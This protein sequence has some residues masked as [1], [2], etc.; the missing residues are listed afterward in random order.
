MMLPLAIAATLLAQASKPQAIT[1]E[2][3]KFF[4]STIRPILVDQCYGCHSA[5]SGRSRGGYVLDTRDA[6]R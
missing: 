4:E 6:A 1:P 5:Q 2:Q 3:L